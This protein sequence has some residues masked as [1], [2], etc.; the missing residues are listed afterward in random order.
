MPGPV[1][2]SKVTMVIKT[3]PLSPGSQDQACGLMVHL[4]THVFGNYW[5]TVTDGKY[6][7]KVLDT[8]TFKRQRLP[9]AR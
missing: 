6:V 3:W 1:L 9:S 5:Q 4:H 8:P 7:C 2:G